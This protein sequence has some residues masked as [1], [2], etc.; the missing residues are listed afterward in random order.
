MNAAESL[1]RVVDDLVSAARPGR[2]ESFGGIAETAEVDENQFAVRMKDGRVLLVEV[3]LSEGDND[4]LFP[5]EDD[6][7]DGSAHYTASDF[8]ADH[9]TNFSD[10]DEK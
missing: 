5:D 8:D 3:T 6:A 9:G 1:R 4:D 7:E 10:D 2:V